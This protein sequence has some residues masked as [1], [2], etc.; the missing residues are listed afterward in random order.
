MLEKG[1]R[2]VF[3]DILDKKEKRVQKAEMDWMD[4]LVKRVSQV[5]LGQGEGRVYLAQ[6]VQWVKK[7]IL[8]EMVMMDFQEDRVSKV[9]LDHLEKMELQ[10]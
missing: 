9:N 6:L 5:N 2:L 10:A 8:E 4:R 3:R 1:E 7:V